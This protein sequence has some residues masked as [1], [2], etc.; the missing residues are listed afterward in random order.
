MSRGCDALIDSEK[1]TT[2]LV[3]SM[4]W[5]GTF[6]SFDGVNTAIVTYV[7]TTKSIT[8]SREAFP[9]HDFYS[10]TTIEP[11]AGKFWQQSPC[12][13]W[14]CRFA[15]VPQ[16]INSDSS[17]AFPYTSTFNGSPAGSG[18]T[19]FTASELSSLIENGTIFCNV[20]SETSR[21][22]LPVSFAAQGGS[23]VG[24]NF[25][26][27]WTYTDNE[28]NTDSGT[29]YNGSIG[30]LLP[31]PSAYGSPHADTCA[32]SQDWWAQIV[33]NGTQ[34]VGLEVTTITNATIKAELSLS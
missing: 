1:P 21:K 19:V 24:Q 2:S 20:N 10:G 16:N 12:C 30:L 7:S 29:G 32:D 27:S 25:P 8:L 33:Y 11:S 5:S 26:L 13:C 28:G 23:P 18:T 3:F 14:K 15:L 22:G 4:T 31:G 9:A 34:T 6:T 17:F